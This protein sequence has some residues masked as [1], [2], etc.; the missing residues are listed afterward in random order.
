MYIYII[1]LLTC[2]LKNSIY[3]H[4]RY[5]VIF[6]V[7]NERFNRSDARRKTTVL[8]MGIADDATARSSRRARVKDP[9]RYFLSLATMH[10][11]L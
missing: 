8:F 10:V 7:R 9:S 2:K 11:Y 5:L 4:I 6:Y 3:M 1:T